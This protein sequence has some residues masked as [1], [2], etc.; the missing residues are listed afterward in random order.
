MRR[1]RLRN[2]YEFHTENQIITQKHRATG[3]KHRHDTGAKNRYSYFLHT[4][5]AKIAKIYVKIAR[6]K[7]RKNE[8]SIIHHY[9]M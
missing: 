6:A 5:F 4:F 1:L 9:S 2:C 3:K 8:K 7:N